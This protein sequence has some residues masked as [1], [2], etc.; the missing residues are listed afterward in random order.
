MKKLLLKNVIA[1][2]LWSV[3][4]TSLT[5]CSTCYRTHKYWGNHRCVNVQKY[6][7]TTQ[8]FAIVNNQIIMFK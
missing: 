6:K 8:Q 2:I 3:L 7:D 5:S 4:I 1:L